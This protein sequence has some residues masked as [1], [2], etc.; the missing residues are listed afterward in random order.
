MVT[1]NALPSRPS[2]ILDIILVYLS[3]GCQIREFRA[4]TQLTFWVTFVVVWLLGWMVTAAAT[5]EFV[6]WYGA[7]RQWDII[8]REQDE[9][10]RP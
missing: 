4:S 6:S 8:E 3:P 9:P 10:E 5:P 1:L 7:K 2:T